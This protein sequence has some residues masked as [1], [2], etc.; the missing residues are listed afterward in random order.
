M[1]SLE[2]NLVI[3]REGAELLVDSGAQ[4]SRGAMLAMWN[5]AKFENVEQCGQCGIWKCEKLGPDKF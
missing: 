2:S 5:D 4:N 1:N 3:M